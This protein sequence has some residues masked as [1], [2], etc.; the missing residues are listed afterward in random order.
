MS[1]TAAKKR[2]D[3]GLRMPEQIVVEQ[4]PISLKI[5]NELYFIELNIKAMMI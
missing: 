5:I 4:H 3:H 2:G 1:E